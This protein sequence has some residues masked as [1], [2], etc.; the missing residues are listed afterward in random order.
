MTDVQLAALFTA[1][2]AE[3][4]DDLMKWTK[5]GTLS[6]T[7]KA[8]LAALSGVLLTW[9]GGV[10]LFGGTTAF[11]ALLNGVVQY[12]LSQMLHTATGA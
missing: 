4:I 11:V 5:A 3:V 2:V 9:V 1:A 8:I 6:P 10:H 12:V 7:A